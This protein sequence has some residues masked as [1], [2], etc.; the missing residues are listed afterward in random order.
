[1]LQNNNGKSNKNVYRKWVTEV[2]RGGSWDGYV[3]LT[4]ACQKRNAGARK[5]CNL[6]EYQIV[7]DWS[8]S[9]LK[10]SDASLKWTHLFQVHLNNC[11]F[12]LLQFFSKRDIVH[13]HCVCGLL[14]L[15]NKCYFPCLF[16]V[17]FKWDSIVHSHC[18]CGLLPFLNKRS[19]PCLFV[20]F[21]FKWDSIVHSH[22]LC[23]LLPFLNKRSF[24]CL[25]VV[26]FFKW[27]SIVHRH[28]LC[29]LLLLLTFS[30]RPPCRCD[31]CIVL[32]CTWWD[33]GQ[34]SQTC[35]HL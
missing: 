33:T 24:P 25:F 18:L 5:M 19:C 9:V 2:G 7:K 31:H 16:Q 13:S 28:C 17:L 10:P 3:P 20:V 14:L 6:Q 4:Y 27:D 34:F 1:M 8:H 35:L 32:W 22:C 23:G 15:L 12:S 29:G 30:W 21:F 26:F 11:Y